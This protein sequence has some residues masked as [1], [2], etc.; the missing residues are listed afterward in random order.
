MPALDTNV[1]VH[2]IVQDDPSQFTAAKRLISRCV[3]DSST[4]F[5]Q[6]RYRWQSFIPDV[7]VVDTWRQLTST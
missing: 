3:A 1:L 7:H 2:Y 4:L 6:G 5:V